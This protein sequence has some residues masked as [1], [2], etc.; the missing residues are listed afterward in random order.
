MKL[1]ALGTQNFTNNHYL[2]HNKA[3]AYEHHKN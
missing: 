3:E 1:A 2:T